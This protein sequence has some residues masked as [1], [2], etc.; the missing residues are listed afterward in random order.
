MFSSDGKNFT[1]AWAGWF[2]QA[3]VVLQDAS[4]SGTT[5]QRPTANLYVGKPYFD[6]TLGYAIN[7]KSTGPTVW[8]N[9]AGTAV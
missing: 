2:A 3:S 9:G 6:T 1:A 5:A 8:V 4:N 7:L